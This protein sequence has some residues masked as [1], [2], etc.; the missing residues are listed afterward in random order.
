MLFAGQLEFFSRKNLALPRINDAL[1]SYVQ[2]RDFADGELWV[3]NAHA[4]SRIGVPIDSLD[5]VKSRRFCGNV[6]IDVWLL[7]RADQELL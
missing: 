2:N 3:E 6:I 5:L 1:L 4:K 7:A